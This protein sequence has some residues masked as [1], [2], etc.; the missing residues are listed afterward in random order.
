MEPQADVEELDGEEP[1]PIFNE[2]ARVV[3]R[4]VFT[5]NGERLEVF[6]PHYEALIRLDPLQ[7][8]ALARRDVHLLEKL[9]SE[10]ANEVVEEK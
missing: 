6:A 1:I 2:F 4:K 9:L 7:L 3:V 10:S 5:H 8:E